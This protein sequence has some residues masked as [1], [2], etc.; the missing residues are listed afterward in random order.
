MRSDLAAKVLDGLSGGESSNRA[1][2]TAD[3][4]S[5]SIPPGVNLIGFVEIDTSNIG[6]LV[7]DIVGRASSSAAD[8]TNWMTQIRVRKW[9]NMYVFS[10]RSGIDVSAE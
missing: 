6:I 2:S 3:G 5:L 10:K 4:C 1:S 7:A 8:P 9:T